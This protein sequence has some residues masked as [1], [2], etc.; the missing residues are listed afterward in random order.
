MYYIQNY[1]IP[2]NNR[3]YAGFR[4]KA[5]Y[6]SG[7]NNIL[8]KHP[9]RPSDYSLALLYTHEGMDGYHDARAAAARANE[10]PGQHS[11]VE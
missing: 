9:K 3:G 4:V 5:E 2:A 7:I 6:S 11:R 10:F 8:P 1:T